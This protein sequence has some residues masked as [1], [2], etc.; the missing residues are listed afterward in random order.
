MTVSEKSAFSR[1]TTFIDEGREALLADPD[2]TTF[3]ELGEED[4]NQQFGITLTGEPNSTFEQQARA[5]AVQIRQNARVGDRVLI[6]CQPGISYLLAFYACTFAGVVAVP[7]CP[8]DRGISSQQDS[9]ESIIADCQ[10]RLAIANGEIYDS[11]TSG[12]LH[13]PRGGSLSMI[14]SEEIN[15]SAADDWR[16]PPVVA[17]DLAFLQ[18]SSGSTGRPKG[19]MVTHA[20]LLTQLDIIASRFL[21]GRQT[22][23]ETVTWLPPYHDM[24]LI[25]AM[26]TIGYSRSAVAIMDPMDFLKQPIKWLQL[27]T[28]LSAGLTGAPNFALTLCAQKVK[29][30]Q[31]SELDLSS[32]SVMFSGAESVRTETLA[33][34]A[35]IFEPAGFN[36]RSYMPSY[37]MA[38]ATLVISST[39]RYEF[40]H[41]LGVSADK[42]RARILESPKSPEDKRSIV[43]CGLT[44]PGHRILIVDPETLETLPDGRVG[45]VWFCGP[46]VAK[47]YW[48]NP[49]LTEKTFCSTPHNE[50]GK[51]LRTGDLGFLQEEK[52]Y[53]VGRLKDLLIINGSNYHPH[54]LEDTI[55]TAHPAICH[56]GVAA[57]ADGEHLN[58]V[59]LVIEVEDQTDHSKVNELIAS[60][61]KALAEKHGI[62]PD[63]LILVQPNSVE[64]TSSGKV[65]RSAT[66]KSL[67]AGQLDGAI[68]WRFDRD[69]SPMN[70]EDL[71]N[72]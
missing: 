8:P 32:L 52:L 30:E 67:M 27:V 44:V 13:L 37:G 51:W 58:R 2:F 3:K 29:P 38:E 56:H 40:H 26:L 70:T 4:L 61:R 15:L 5:L 64:K 21:S 57:F 20:N 22:R 69:G 66:R 54:D 39:P 42:L 7:C 53:I 47:G 18:Y 12:E 36:P 55:A 10:P 71:T 14:S 28:K 68:R 41:E 6:L 50:E 19:V 31:L 35:Q 60:V 48:R 63:E 62:I 1:T 59:I 33:L 9:L 25:G 65:R 23:M 72:E 49:E 45:E 11:A 43:S 34:F 46:S 17:D 16:R 24:G